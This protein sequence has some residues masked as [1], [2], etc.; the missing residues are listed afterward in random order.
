MPAIPK[1]D[2]EVPSAAPLALLAALPLAVL[3]PELVAV[4]AEL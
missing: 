2:A 3:T 4:V 1:V